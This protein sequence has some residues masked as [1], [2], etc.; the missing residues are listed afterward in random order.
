MLK[1]CLCNYNRIFYI[2]CFSYVKE[3]GIHVRNFVNILVCF[4]FENTKLSHLYYALDSSSSS[5]SFRVL[6]DIRLSI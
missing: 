5:F 4:K 1:K 2:F 6:N 3:V